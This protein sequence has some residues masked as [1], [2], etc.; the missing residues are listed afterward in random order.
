MALEPDAFVGDPVDRGQG[1]DLIAAGVGE[2]RP[3]PAHE[4]VQAAPLADQL[5][6]GT[7]VKVI[8]VGQ[9]HP[10]AQLVQLLGREGLDGGLRAHGHEA[11]RRHAAVR[12]LP[13]ARACRAVARQ[14]PEATDV[15]RA[16]GPLGR[17]GAGGAAHTIAI[18]SP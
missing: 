12:E 4:L 10:R 17:F 16:F 9:E 11:R 5:V 3:P 13:V 7:Q 15:G 6:A 2:D 1:E 14:D 18:A 8:G